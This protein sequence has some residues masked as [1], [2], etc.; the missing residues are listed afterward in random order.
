MVGA[1]SKFTTYRRLNVL[2]GIVGAHY[3]IDPYG[4]WSDSVTI[5]EN[6]HNACMDII[7][8]G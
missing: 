5:S 4:D 7:L 6:N 3:P 1:A 8:A 2:L